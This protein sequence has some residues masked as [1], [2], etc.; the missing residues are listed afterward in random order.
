VGKKREEKL[1]GDGESLGRGEKRG[2]GMEIA[3]GGEMK[4][5]SVATSVATTKLKCTIYI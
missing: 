4:S 1:D 3:G 2:G 5:F